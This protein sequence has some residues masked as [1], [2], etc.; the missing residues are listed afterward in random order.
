VFPRL[1]KEKERDIFI[2]VKRVFLH[3]MAVFIFLSYFPFLA[4]FQTQE[5]PA[6]KP[7]YDYWSSFFSR[8]TRPLGLKENE[9]LKRL[10][11]QSN[12]KW[13]VRTGIR[14]ILS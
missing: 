5:F 9:A 10:Q 13:A 14:H 1:T 7:K 12:I 2:I 3:I 4:P 8:N 11:K 6:K